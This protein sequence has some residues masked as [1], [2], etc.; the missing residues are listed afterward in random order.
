MTD[1]RSINGINP[2]DVPVAKVRRI[3]KPSQPDP[4]RDRVDISAVATKAAEVAAYTEL[5]K[6]VSD[7]RIDLVQ[8]AQARVADGSYLKPEVTREVARKILDSL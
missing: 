7:I 4:V 6:G 2:S 5:A 1:V 8:Q 3:E